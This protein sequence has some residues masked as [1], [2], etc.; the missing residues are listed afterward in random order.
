MSDDGFAADAELDPG[1]WDEEVESATSAGSLTKVSGVDAKLIPFVSVR[2][3]D[4]IVRQSQSAAQELYRRH[5]DTDLSALLLNRELV[6]KQV[7]TE[8]D[9]AQNW[10]VNPGELSDDSLMREN[11]R[12]WRKLQNVRE[13]IGELED[14]IRAK[15]EMLA[16]IREQNRRLTAIRIGR[17]IKQTE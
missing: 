2:A 6:E 12:L 4:S 17:E 1:W 11:T 7:G 15:R 9:G 3:Y 14:S 8:R 5:F 13:E 10:R 16:L